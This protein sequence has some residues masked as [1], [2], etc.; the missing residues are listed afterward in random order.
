MPRD[1]AADQLRLR[2]AALRHHQECSVLLPRFHE[3]TAKISANK[4]PEY[5]W[6]VYDW[7]LA[8]VSIWPIDFRG[9]AEYLLKQ[10]EDGKRI[11]PS[12]YLLL[13]LLGPPP[14]EPA[15]KIFAAFEHEMANG[16]YEKL[17]KQPQKYQEHETRLKDDPAL[18][19]QWTKLKRTFD[20]KKW[21][22]KGGVIRRSLSLERSLRPTM[23]C[24]WNRRDARF[25][26]LFDAFCY[27]WHLYGMEH[28]EPLPLK[29]SV[30]PTAH[31]TLIVIPRHWSFDNKR[32]LDWT[33]IGALHKAHGA[34]RQ[35]P[36]VSEV[37][38][39]FRAKAKRLKALLAVTR[40]KGMRGFA[41]DEFLR[42]EL[43]LHQSSDLKRLMRMASKL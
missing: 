9:V 26:A 41:R 22:T 40:E 20:V 10:L 32:D 33:A 27:R 43:K 37:R 14:E 4:R 34:K 1:L 30:N 38:M 35:G 6:M 21:R 25:L 13:E 5:I 29:P 19:A 3:L 17:L 31:G 28:D 39:A 15:Q 42:K 18:R 2:N 36:C 23:A 16:R 11:D 24:D 8:P 7:I 12:C